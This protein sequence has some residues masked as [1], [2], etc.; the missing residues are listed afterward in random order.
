MND[1]VELISDDE[2]EA[3]QY[4]KGIKEFYTHAFMFIVFA[5]TLLLF[6]DGSEPV[7]KWGLLGWGAGLIIHGL[8]A[9]EK[10]RLIGV[11][12]EK[13]QVEKRLGR[14]L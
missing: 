14:K 13:R 5:V 2:N 11:S 10:I 9:F 1:K 8:V 3:I 6:K 4:V 7:I 12:W